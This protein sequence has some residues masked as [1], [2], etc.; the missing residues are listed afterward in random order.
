MARKVG[1]PAAA[2]VSH[3]VQD[4]TVDE[5]REDLELLIADDV[6]AGL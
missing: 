1:Q 6:E 2:E 5:V 4:Q 3:L